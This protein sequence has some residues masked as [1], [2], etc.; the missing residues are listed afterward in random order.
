MRQMTRLAR[1]RLLQLASQALPIGGYSHSQGLESA[2]ES[3]LVHDEASTHGWL[4]DVLHFSFGCYELPV[5]QALCGAWQRRDAAGLGR[6]NEE[7][8]ATRE[9]AELRAA[10]VQMGFSMRALVQALRLASPACRAS[11]ADWQRRGRSLRSMP[12]WPMPG[13]GRKTRCWRP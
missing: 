3:G 5:L 10:T 12:A 1:T 9:S 7:F 4:A 13:T 6:L 8:L 2:V 11:G